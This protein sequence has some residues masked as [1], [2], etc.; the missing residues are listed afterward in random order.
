MSN[1][2]PKTTAEVLS[3][4]DQV[5]AALEATVGRL[6]NAQLT[7]VRDPAGWAVKDHLMHV[8]AWEDAFLARLTGRPTHEALGLDENALAGDEDAENAALF[9]RHRHRPL[10]EVLDALRASHRAARAR[11][12]ALGDRALAGTV[13]DVLPPGAEKDGSPAVAWIAGN[14]WE[15]Y[16]SHHGW[17]R[18]LIDRG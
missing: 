11:L 13:A 10:A 4:L 18:D 16:E 14:T 15:H 17:I 8:A 2:V 1:A 3:R 12:A 9:E 7:E 6:S 5:W